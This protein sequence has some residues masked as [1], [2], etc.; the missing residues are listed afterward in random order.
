MLSQLVT[1]TMWMGAAHGAER[2]DMRVR[3]DFFAGFGGDR[4]RLERGMQTTAETL[5]R[6]PQH[7]EALV[8]HGGGLFF[9]AGDAF[10]K[11]DS[12]RGVELAQRGIEEMDRA[13]ALAP[14]RIG[15][16]IPRGSTLIT[17]TRFMQPSPRA[18]ELLHKGLADFERA[19]ELQSKSFDTLGGHARGELLF[20]L[21]E[22]YLRAGDTEKAKMWFEKLAAS[23]GAGHGDQAR[24]YLA[25]GKLTGGATCTGCHVGK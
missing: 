7:P 8:W 20:G 11:G 13:V 14:D 3:D 21:A 22:G 18:T 23:P 12:A 1:M 24:A 17:A 9:Q 10:A 25:S 4:A 2:F 19:Y 6:D 16:R 15:V 5:A